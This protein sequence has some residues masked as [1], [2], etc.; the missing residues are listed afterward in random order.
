VPMPDLYLDVACCSCGK[1]HTLFDPSR[2]RQPDESKGSF[3]C[4]TTSK[5]VTVLLSDPQSVILAPA[6][7]V[8]VAWVPG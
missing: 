1:S 5:P 8:P 3:K 6:E 4:P 7:A 2:I